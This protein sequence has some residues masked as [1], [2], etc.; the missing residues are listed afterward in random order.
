[1][2]RALSAVSQDL[3]EQIYSNVLHYIDNVSNV[4]VCRVKSLKSMVQLL[5]S[6]YIV[7]DKVQFYPIEI[8]HLLDIFSVNRRYL[9]DNNFI[10]QS[11]IDDMLSTSPYCFDEQLSSQYSGLSTISSYLSTDTSAAANGNIGSSKPQYKLD[12]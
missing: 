4:D 11:F 2:W 8:Q 9:L 5:G 3:G 10:K 12:N 7:L 1:M 6:S